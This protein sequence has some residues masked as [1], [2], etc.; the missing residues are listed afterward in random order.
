MS[1]SLPET[2]AWTRLS[3]STEATVVLGLRCGMW[4]WRWHEPPPP[5]HPTTLHK[6]PHP[7]VL[8]WSDSRYC[9]RITWGGD[10]PALVG[11][12]A[13]R[14]GQGCQGRDVHPMLKGSERETGRNR[15]LAENWY[16]HPKKKKKISSLFCL[17]SLPTLFFFLP[18]L[19]HSLCTLCFGVSGCLQRR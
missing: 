18:L 10:N 17:T 7:A 13:G 11:S 19:C 5:T 16:I 6:G 12:G 14:D 15:D 4:C 9:S 2:Q 8:L 3:W 1:P